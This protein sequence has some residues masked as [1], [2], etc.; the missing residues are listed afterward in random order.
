MVKEVEA[1][2]NRSFAVLLFRGHITDDILATVE[3]EV[4]TNEARVQKMRDEKR[5]IYDIR[6]QAS[7]ATHNHRYLIW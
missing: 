4:I 3:K 5:D 2:G 7:V 1:Y 6:K